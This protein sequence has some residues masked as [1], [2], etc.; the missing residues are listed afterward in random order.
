M[1]RRLLVSY[2]KIIAF[3]E[4]ECIPQTQ[5]LFR[6]LFLLLNPAKGLL[7]LWEVRR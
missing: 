2:I 1:W 3:F 7:G 4:V 6:L 5:V